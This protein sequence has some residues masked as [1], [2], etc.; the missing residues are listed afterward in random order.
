MS[1]KEQMHMEKTNQHLHDYLGARDKH[2]SV[3]VQQYSFLIAFKILIALTLLIVGGF[4]V[5]NQQMNIGQF[6]ASE[7]I[8]LLV[9]SSV[10]K[11]ILSLDVIYDVFTAIEKIGQ[12][13]DLPLEVHEGEILE[14]NTDVGMSVSI[15]DLSFKSH[16]SP[17]KL[18]DHLTI[19]IQSNQLVSIVSDSSAS[20]NALFYLM[21][22]ICDNAKG[23]ISFDNV[24]Q[25]NLNSAD[26]REQ[27]GT[28]FEHD[29]L[30]NGSIFE[31][32]QFGRKDVSLKMV[33][34]SSEE[35]GLADFIHSLPEKYET[36]IDSEGHFIP[37]DVELKILLLRSLA[38]KPRLLLLN[39]PTAAI[40]ANQ[41]EQILKMISASTC[42]TRIIATQDPEIHKISDLVLYI[43]NGKVRIEESNQSTL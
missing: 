32:I 30:I 8:I 25:I 16:F 9:L 2:F 10:E 4:L 41:K 40:N 7:I 34:Q 6:V 23:S 12:V 28:L 11:L 20:S 33:V 17:K 15:R 39:E 24:P 43:E 14:N 42:A 19:E 21:T 37:R 29:H 18:L 13:T 31:N 3:L 1:S 26:L 5:I 27:I 36:H 35:I 22:G 38:K